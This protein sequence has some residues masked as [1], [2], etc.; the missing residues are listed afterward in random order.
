[1]SE[2]KYS[3]YPSLLIAYQ[4]LLDYQMVAEEP[5]N[6]V[7][8]SSHKYGEFLDYN[9]GDYKLTPDEMYLELEADL[10]DSI[11]RVPRTFGEA[12]SKGTAFNE[13]VDCLIENRKSS[14]P[15][16]KIHSTKNNVGLSVIRAE[17]DGFVFDF[18]IAL[19]KEVAKAFPHSLAQYFAE[20]T[21]DTRFGMVHLY[22]YID[23]WCGKEMYDIKTT[24]DYHWGKFANGWQRH[25]YPYCVINS[26]ESEEVESFT[27][28]VVEWAKQ[29]A[30]EPIK[31]KNIYQEYYNYDHVE[32]T[33]K[34]R[35]IVESFIDWLQYR[36][37]YIQ[38]KKIYGGT[39]PKDWHGIPIDRTEFNN[40]F[41]KIA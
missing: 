23:E 26:G 33:D 35:D 30:G 34:I 24:G 9:I 31:A 14:N 37:E 29:P 28:Y 13:I 20:S 11:N 19:C 25:I 40:N 41:P 38:D 39:N 2:I 32:S 6:K 22:G 21:I 4:R 5:W 15:N 7:S 18:D 27:Y 12:A 1:M 16:C 17:I 3:I 10:I 8:E 36:A